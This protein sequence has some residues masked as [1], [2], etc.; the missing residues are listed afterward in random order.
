MPTVYL[1]KKLYD[2]LVQKGED[3]GSFVNEAVEFKL[4]DR[5]TKLEEDHRKAKEFLEKDMEE[6]RAMK[7]VMDSLTK[8]GVLKEI[9][10]NA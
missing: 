10:I 5:V 4:S 6:L 2:K 8:N 9:E 1:K 3:I 7:K